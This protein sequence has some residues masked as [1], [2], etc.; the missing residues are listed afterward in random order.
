[1]DG[2]SESATSPSFSFS[3]A[4]PPCY[5]AGTQPFGVKVSELGVNLPKLAG[6][7]KR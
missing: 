7:A 5:Q 3:G 6:K 1:M 2:A 4:T